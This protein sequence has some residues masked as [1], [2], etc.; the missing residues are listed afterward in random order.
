M[1]TKP[2][3]AQR[4]LSTFSQMTLLLVLAFGAVTTLTLMEAPSRSISMTAEGSASA[5]R[6]PASFGVELKPSAATVATL[7]VS[8]LSSMNIKTTA[9]HVRLLADGCLEHSELRVSNETRETTAVVFQQDGR[10]TTDYL[11]LAMGE[12]VILVEQSLE[13]KSTRVKH[14]IIRE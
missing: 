6:Q 11:G 10:R 3:L 4:A 13:G 7:K 12:N 14:V 5:K 8:C 2:N 9:Q 1:A